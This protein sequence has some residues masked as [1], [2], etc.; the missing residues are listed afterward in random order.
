[1]EEIETLLA[2]AADHCQSTGRPWVTLSYAQSLDG[3]IAARPRQPLALSGQKSLALTHQLRAAHDA[4]LVG[5][6]TVLA[7]NPRL[8]VRLVEGVNPQPVVVDGHLRFPLEARLLRD[9]PLSPWIATSEHAGQGRQRALEQAGARVLRL[10]ADPDGRVNLASLLERLGTLGITCLMV[11][12]GARIITSF[13]RQRLADLLVLT[14]SPLLVGGLHAV[15]DLGEADP[16]CFPRLKK[17]RHAW[18]GEDLILWGE[19]A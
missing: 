1:M 8:T 7:D 10:P 15:E 19:L 3:C 17:P 9:H 14:V 13:L 5:I 18:R 11:E 2:K 16:A 6:G 12:G 4:I